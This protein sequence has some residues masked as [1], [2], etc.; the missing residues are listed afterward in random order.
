MKSILLTRLL[1]FLAHL[2]FQTAHAAGPID[3]ALSQVRRLDDDPL[4]FVGTFTDEITGTEFDLYDHTTTSSGLDQYLANANAANNIDTGAATTNGSSTADW[5]TA[6]EARS[7]W[8]KCRALSAQLIRACCSTTHGWDNI[9]KDIAVGTLSNLLSDGIVAA[10]SNGRGNQKPRSI[11]HTYDSNNLCTSWA[12]YDAQN[13]PSGE[14]GDL[15]GFAASCAKEG[16]S[17]EFKA[18]NANG[19]MIFVCISNRAKGC[20]THIG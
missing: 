10:F 5:E 17:S 19:G 14:K 18:T 13:I 3:A 1:L 12:T 2:G 4:Y 7:N 20:G 6:I 16:Y 9:F 15:A 8:R 11:C